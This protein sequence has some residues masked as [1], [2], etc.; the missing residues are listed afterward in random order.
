[1]SFRCSREKGKRKSSGRG[2]SGRKKARGRRRR[3]HATLGRTHAALR[4]RGRAHATLGRTHGPRENRRQGHSGRQAEGRS[5]QQK[6]NK[7]ISETIFSLLKLHNKEVLIKTIII[8][9]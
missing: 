9:F 6:S 4:G 1:L 2:G 7:E 3:S 5:N 8:Y